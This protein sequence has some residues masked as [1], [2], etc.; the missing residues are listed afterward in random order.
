VFAD[1]EAAGYLRRSKERDE[2]G[3][4]RTVL[5]VYDAPVDNAVPDD[6]PGGTSGRPAETDVCPARTDVPPT[7]VPPGGP[8]TRRRSTKT[9]NSPLPS[10][11]G[12]R[13]AAPRKRDSADTHSL[14]R[15]DAVYDELGADVDEQSKG[16]A[17]F[18]NGAH[19][20]AIRNTL[21][22]DRRSEEKAQRED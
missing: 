3:H 20:K 15:L 10:V 1:L 16:D 9:E 4:W 18:S 14:D 2:R 19:P 17:M 21:L 7:D 22:A 6:T 13:H 11:A 8:S 12:S 5:T